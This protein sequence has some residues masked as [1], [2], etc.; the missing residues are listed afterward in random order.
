MYGDVPGAPGLVFVGGV[1]GVVEKVLRTMLY[2]LESVSEFA[3]QR[4]ILR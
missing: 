1:L 4:E 2:M 3:R